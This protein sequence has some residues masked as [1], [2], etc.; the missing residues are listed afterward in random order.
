MTPYFIPILVGIIAAPFLDVNPLRLLAGLALFAAAILTGTSLL[1]AS[2][3][4]CP[5][6]CCSCCK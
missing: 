6:R 2:P 3:S 4:L 1:S 5:S